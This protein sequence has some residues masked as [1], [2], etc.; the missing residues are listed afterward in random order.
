[1]GR[2]VTPIFKVTMIG[3]RGYEIWFTKVERETRGTFGGRVSI[4]VWNETRDRLIRESF[5]TT[6]KEFELEHQRDSFL[7]V[8]IARRDGMIKGSLGNLIKRAVDAIPK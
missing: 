1:M 6:L 2:I 4:R 3:N 5:K 8:E 7:A